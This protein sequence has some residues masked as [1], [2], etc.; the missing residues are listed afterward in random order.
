M[1]IG[2]PTEAF[3]SLLMPLEGVE[4]ESTA[5]QVS[6]PFG[7]AALPKMERSSGKSKMDDEA[8]NR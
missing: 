5:G 6:V 4:D 1:L 7:A 2:S 8:G 3:R